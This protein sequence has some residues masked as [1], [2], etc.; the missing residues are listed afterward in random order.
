[1]AADVILSIELPST[2]RHV[3]LRMRDELSKRKASDTFNPAGIFLLLVDCRTSAAA[4]QTRLLHSANIPAVMLELFR[5][6]VVPGCRLLWRC[7]A[8]Y[9]QT[10]H[11]K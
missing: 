3:E 7:V 10:L 8:R 4:H 11:P 9:P 6:R 2:Y 1:M 5:V